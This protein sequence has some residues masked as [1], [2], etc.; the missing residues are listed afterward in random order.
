M[1]ASTRLVEKAGNCGEFSETPRRQTHTA[2]CRVQCVHLR[3][4]FTR[5]TP[6]LVGHGLTDHLLRALPLGPY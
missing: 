5:M 4:L 1:A 3:V 6:H 2:Q